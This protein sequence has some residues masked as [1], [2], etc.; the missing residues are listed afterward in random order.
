MATLLDIG[1]LE[2]FEGLFP[3][4]LVMVVLYAFLSRTDWFGE[5]KGLA[6][7]IAVLAGFMTVVSDIAIKTVNLMAPW[8][9]LLIVF[10]VFF[11]LAY[12]VFGYNTKDITDFISKGG[13]GV[14]NWVM[15]IMIIIG[16]GSLM[17]VVNEEVGV[18]G[19]AEDGEAAAQPA[20]ESGEFGFWETLFHEK[21][22]GLTLLLLVSFFTIKY[23][24]ETS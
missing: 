4:L 17:F 10:T 22:L 19:L 21:V 15:A 18:R 20:P 5:R 8:F 3:F 9:V 2:H 13:G 1:A 16:V 6:A 11:M 24:S 23:M 12:M 7:I 14:G